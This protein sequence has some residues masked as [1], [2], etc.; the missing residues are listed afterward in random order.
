[1]HAVDRDAPGVA[2]GGDDDDPVNPVARGGADLLGD[3]ARF[4]GEVAAQGGV[5]AGHER[6]GG[7]ASR[8]ERGGDHF[9]VDPLR[10]VGCQGARVGHDVD[11]GLAG[12]ERPAEVVGLPGG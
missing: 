3:G 6:D 11:G 2:E 9:A 1:M 10:V 4:E 5:G 12:G 7:I 8:L